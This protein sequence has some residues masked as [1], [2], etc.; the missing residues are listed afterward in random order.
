MQAAGH[1]LG[2]ILVQRLEASWL[3]VQPAAQVFLQTSGSPK[4]SLLQADSW[5]R[6]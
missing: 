6:S 2:W 4:S 1:G 5:P 3:M